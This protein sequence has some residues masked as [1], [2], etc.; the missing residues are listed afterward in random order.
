MRNASPHRWSFL[1]VLVWLLAASATGCA[2]LHQ[3]IYG[4]GPM[5]PAAYDGLANKKVA[6]VCQLNAS[7]YSTATTGEDIARLVGQR[8]QQRVDGIQVVRQDEVAD[9]IDNNNWDK[10][11]FVEIGNGVKADMVVGIDI[12]SFRI[13]D[14]KT[15]YKGRAHVVT[16]VYDL[17]AGGREVYQSDLPEYSFPENHGVHA[18][19]TREDKF[20]RLFVRML[21]DHVAKYFYKYEAKEDFA[22]DA[23]A[24]AH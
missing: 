7:S 19:D 24:Y 23:A 16:T 17:S 21:A 18:T 20:Q 9:W 10:M 13:H 8:L 12:D 11:D 1:L 2:V 14:G 15:M 3:A 5:I 6:V 4:D 22:R